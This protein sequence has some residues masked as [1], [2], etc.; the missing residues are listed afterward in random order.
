MAL[1]FP[2]T[3]PVDHL[4]ASSVAT[5]LR[6]P[7]QW[8][9]KY[10]D[11][12]PQAPKLG[13]IVGGAVGA[14]EGYSY[15]RV[16]D[17]GEQAKLP[18]AL[19]LYDE[20]FEYKLSRAD[21][22]EASRQE[23]GEA[24][25]GGVRALSVY[26]STIAPKTEP[27]SVERKFEL[28]LGA[29]EWTVNGFFDVETPRPVVDLKVKAK[30][31]TQADAD[32]DLQASLYLAARRAEGNPAPALDFHVSTTAKQASAEVVSTRRSEAQL[33]Q[34]LRLVAYVARDIEYRV[35]SGNWVGAPPLAWWCAAGQCPY[36]SSCPFGG[37][38]A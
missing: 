3:L 25:D 38:Y 10:L 24:K 11:H 8:R 35:A 34:T 17:G 5:Y 6:C 31:L 4:S 20:E 16:I 30:R 1:E 19:D 13:M 33:D 27:K 26:H 15:Q 36:W 2:T 21:G 9:R 7:E 23:R 28:R 14:V 22:L 12:E 18:E 37:R 32:S 29:A